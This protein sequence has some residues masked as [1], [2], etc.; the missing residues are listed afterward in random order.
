MPSNFDKL[1]KG[2][3]VM[4]HPFNVSDKQKVVHTMVWP[5]S[6]FNLLLLT[7]YLY[8]YLESNWTINYQQS[9]AEAHIHSVGTL[10][11]CI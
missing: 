11:M 8:A 9:S 6:A 7:T 10:R 1:H 2:T 4:Q 5:S 3:E